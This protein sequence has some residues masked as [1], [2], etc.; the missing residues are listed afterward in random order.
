MRN[1]KQR[2]IILNIINNSCEHLTAYQVYEYARSEIS[3]ISLGTVY[4]NL[5]NLTDEGKIRKLELYGI[6]R[7]D[8]KDMHSHFVCVKCESI[9]DV[10]DSILHNDKYI[11]GN[12][13]IDYDIK[14]N[15]ICKKCMGGNDL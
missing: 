14:I 15:G 1:T 8:K 13:V 9:I 4:R 12:L 11:D 3:N 5:S 2:N 7:Y 10:F 6:D